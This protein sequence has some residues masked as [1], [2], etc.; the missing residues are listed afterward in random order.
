MDVTEQPFLTALG[1]RYK[2]FHGN[3]AASV[4]AQPEM[5]NWLLQPLSRWS[6][7]AFGDEI[8]QIAA[9]GY[10]RYATIV[11]KSQQEYETLGHYPQRSIESVKEEVYDNPEYMIPYMWAAVLIYAYWPS[12]IEHLRLYRDEFV[13]TVPENGTILELACGHGVLGLLAAEQRKDIR[14]EGIDISPAAIAIAEKLAA[15]S[16]HES[17]I[18]LTVGDALQAGKGEV[19]HDGVIAA[20]LAE[21]LFDPRPMFEAVAARLKPGA[22]AYISTALESAQPD[23]VFEFHRESEPILLA[24]EFGLRVVRLVSDRAGQAT[25]SGFLP[26]AIAMIVELR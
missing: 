21:H 25:E 9:K 20:M 2:R 7:A 3:A 19:K 14:L 5:A 24:E 18:N 4:A 15:V 1:E 26:R 6:Q 11:A 17:R 16:G 13:A 8:F 12:M 23:H 10:A 22:R